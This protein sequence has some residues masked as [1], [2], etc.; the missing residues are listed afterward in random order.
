[1]NYISHYYEL[2]ENFKFFKL[3]ELKKKI[4]KKSLKERQQTMLK[5]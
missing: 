1:M 5:I 4:K 2:N 3:V